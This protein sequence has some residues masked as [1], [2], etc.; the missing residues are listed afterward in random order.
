[1][2]ASVRCALLLAAMCAVAP[3][4]AQIGLPRLPTPG[5]PPLPTG[6]LPLPLPAPVAREVGG[7]VQPVLSSVRS[8]AREL[9]QKYPGQV[10]RDPEGDP[11]VRAVILALAPDEQ[12]LQQALARGYRIQTDQTLQP[13][14]DRVI[15]LL[16]P[17]GV[18]TRRALRDL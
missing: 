7:L 10:E 8:R 4:S 17:A 12:A 1:M 11:I 13:L 3:S 6:N 16:V 2:N 15:T 14:G 9:T 5:L 18:T